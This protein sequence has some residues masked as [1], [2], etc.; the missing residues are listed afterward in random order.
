MRAVVIDGYGGPEVLRL[1]EVPVPVPGPSQV[2]IRVHTAGVN[3]VDAKQRGGYFSAIAQAQFPLRLGN[4]YAGVVDQ[5]G[6][7]V[8]G[9]S[10]GDEVLGSATGQCYADWVV[11][12]AADTVAKPASMGWDVAG[13]IATV[14]QT[15]YT[16]LTQIGGVKDGDTLLVH[17]AAGGVG[18]MAV[19][20]A[21]LWGATVIGTASEHNHDYLRSLGAIP[22]AYGPGLV[23]RVREIA[24]QG[25]DAA[26][27][28]IG[29]DATAASLELVADRDRIGTTIDTEGAEKYGFHRVGGRTTPGLR[30][31]VDWYRIGAVKIP[32][33]TVYP[34][35]HAAAAHRH[36]EAGHTQGKVVLQVR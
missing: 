11:V 32:S 15:A 17:A 6:D 31:V 13:G 20:I 14:G 1:S 2:R 18:T 3:P 5:L 34:L 9:I 35:D 26:L 22:V 29:G 28:A 7:G 24:P 19:Q 33:V 23:E 4:E 10:V 36:V 27:D 21:R 30:Q 8:E 25:L 12:E 16:A